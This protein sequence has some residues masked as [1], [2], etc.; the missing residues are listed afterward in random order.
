MVSSDHKS[1]DTVQ[2]SRIDALVAGGSA[3]EI[4]SHNA[5]V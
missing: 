5:S 2:L 1:Q 3:V 4:R